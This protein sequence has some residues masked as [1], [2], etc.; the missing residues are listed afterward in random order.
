MKF[1]LSPVIKAQR[2]STGL[3]FIN[4]SAKWGWVVNAKPIRFTPWNALVPIV[5]EDG[6]ISGPVWT[7]AKNHASTG[8]S[9]PGPPSPSVCGQKLNTQ[10]NRYFAAGSWSTTFGESSCSFE[11]I[12]ITFSKN[13]SFQDVTCPGA[14]MNAFMFV[15]FMLTPLPAI[16]PISPVATAKCHRA[17][18]KQ[19]FID[20]TD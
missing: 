1:T 6:W 20:M 19:H 2:V 16:R 10:S 3:L 11:Y 15:I 12:G 7:S 9:I 5:Q 18:R 13:D 8:N 4:L 17:L 14:L